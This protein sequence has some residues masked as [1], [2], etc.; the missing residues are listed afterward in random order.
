MNRVAIKTTPKIYDWNLRRK[1][2][3]EDQRVKP[4]IEQL[5]KN[6]DGRLFDRVEIETINRCNNYCEFCPV[7]VGADPRTF[8][9]M[10][11]E[12]FTGIIQ[13]LKS[14]N[15]NGCLGLFSNNEPLLDSKIIKRVEYARAMLP[16][17]F[18][19]MYTNGLLLNE[20]RFLGLVKNLDLLVID[21]YADKLLPGVNDVYEK[22]KDEF[23]RVVIRMRSKDEVL[24]TRGGLAGNRGSIQSLN[25]P[26]VLPFTQMV[27]RPDGKVSLCCNDAYGNYT[28]GDVT[29]ES[30]KDIWDGKRY[31]N[32]RAL[33]LQGRKNLEICNGCDTLIT[34]LKMFTEL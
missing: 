10:T 26:C 30:L 15:Y 18:H 12:T 33:L 34:S 6:V 24:T 29:K 2:I 21:N 25:S 28:L 5:I 19:Y 13:D 7:H 17:A 20:K 4:V 27:I 11:D 16:G 23:S 31:A 8:A 14:L 22:H 32:I 9:R 1:I 3:E